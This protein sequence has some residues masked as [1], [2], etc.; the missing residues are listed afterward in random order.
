MAAPGRFESFS[1]LK[2]V[3]DRWLLAGKNRNLV[4]AHSFITENGQ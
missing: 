1:A 2:I 3:S 4:S